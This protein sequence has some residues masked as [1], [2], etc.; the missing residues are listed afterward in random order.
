MWNMEKRILK[1]KH[2]KNI[3]RGKEVSWK[4]CSQ[5]N[6]CKCSLTYK[7]LNPKL[8]NDLLQNDKFNENWK[9]KERLTN[10]MNSPHAE[11]DPKKNLYLQTNKDEDPKNKPN[12]NLTLN[13][14][15]Q[16]SILSLPNPTIPHPK[17]WIK[18][19]VYHYP[20]KKDLHGRRNLININQESH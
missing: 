13:N 5:N 11:P 8:R 15:P 14:K 16:A 1:V 10:L 18:M 19:K 17:N 12:K 2:T 3:S 7:Q 6:L 9:H 4:F 20:Q